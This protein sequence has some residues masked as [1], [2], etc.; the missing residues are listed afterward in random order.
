MQEEERPQNTYDFFFL[1]GTNNSY[2]FETNLGIVYEIKFKPSPY[3]FPSESEYSAN[4][5]EFAIEVFLNP[6]PTSPPFDK[7]SSKTIAYIFED[8]YQRNI[9]TVTIYLCDSS[10]GRQMVRHRKFNIWFD[11]FNQEEYLKL[12]RILKDIHGNIFPTSLIMKHSNP[13][14]EQII[15]EFEAITDGYG[16]GK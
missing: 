16:T 7:K 4:A 3:L 14:K 1:G 15:H 8:F 2:G 12:D 5:F 11:E 13:F 10:D 9:E 6:N